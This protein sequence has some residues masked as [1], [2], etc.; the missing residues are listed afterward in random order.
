MTPPACFTVPLAKTRF[1]PSPLIRFPRF[2]YSKT[3]SFGQLSTPMDTAD[4]VEQMRAQN[5]PKSSAA[6]S[7]SRRSDA[8]NRIVERRRGEA[9]F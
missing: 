9:D 1:T 5:R 8:L 6:T 7:R 4:T 2:R 3:L